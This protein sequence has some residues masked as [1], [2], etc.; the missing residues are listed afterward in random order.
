M[1]VDKCKTT[2]SSGKSYTRYLL[3]ESYRQGKKVKNRTLMNLTP[4][5]E[6]ACE[7]IRLAMKHKGSLKQLLADAG[8]KPEIRQGPSFGAVWLLS[9]VARKL[10]I[11]KALSDKLQGKLAL[12]QFRAWNYPRCLARASHQTPSVTSRPTRTR[13][14]PSTGCANAT[15]RPGMPSAILPTI[16]TLPSQGFAPALP[17]S[18]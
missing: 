15:K 10:G 4:F 14:R 17:P 2:T 11:T 3:R 7:A 8:T 13:R 18:R 12:W 1:Y 6:E 9:Q 5:G 16:H